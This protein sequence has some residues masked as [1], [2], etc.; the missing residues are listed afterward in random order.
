MADYGREVQFGVFPSPK[1]DSF[2]RIMEIASMADRGL[3]LI[4]I[5]D[6]PYQRRFLDTWSLMATILARTHQV[7]VFPDVAS[8]PLRPPAVMA[9]AAASMDVMSNGRF[10]LGLGAGSFWEAIGAMG[11]PQRSGAEAASALEEAVR[12][13]RLMWSQERSVRFDGTHYQLNGVRPG[14]APVHPIGIWLGVFG[15]RMLRLLGRE[16]DGWVPSS[17]YVPPAVLPDKH[18]R[19]DDAAADAGRDPATIRRVYNVM[20]TITEGASRGFLE[21]PVDQ[22]VEELTELVVEYGMD[23]FLLAAEADDPFQIRVFSEEV[24]PAVR[25][26]VADARR[27]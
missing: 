11:G 8:L 20:G 13:I 22:W 4:G 12:V 19:I 21:G 25:S 1:A 3:D 2:D 17:S 14:P 16:A 6:H 9:K 26:A 27:T 5:Q 18:V 7:H 24:A 15:P 10:E 23:T